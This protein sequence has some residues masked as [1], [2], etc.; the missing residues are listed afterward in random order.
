MFYENLTPRKTK[1]GE[2]VGGFSLLCDEKGTIQERK[3]LGL[4]WRCTQRKRE[5]ESSK[6]KAKPDSRVWIYTWREI[7]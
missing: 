5:R 2:M 4:Q 3:K 7:Q 1:A 6:G